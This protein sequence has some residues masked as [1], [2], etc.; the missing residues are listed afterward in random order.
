ML[1]ISNVPGT[2]CFMSVFTRLVRTMQDQR[3]CIPQHQTLWC[4]G[5]VTSIVG[6]YLPFIVFM[7]CTVLV[8]RKVVWLL[9][10]MHSNLCTDFSILFRYLCKS[11]VN[12]QSLYHCVLYI[13][14]ATR[15]YRTRVNKISFRPIRKIR[16]YL[17][18]YSRDLQIRNRN[19]CWFLVLN[20]TQTGRKCG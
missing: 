8:L 20:F 18:R 9:S 12:T 6:L 17:R 4:I 11:Y 3:H 7:L 2:G 15:F 19:M 14:N 1:G 5:W 10:V 16:P 13:E